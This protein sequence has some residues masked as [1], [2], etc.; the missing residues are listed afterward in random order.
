MEKKFEIDGPIETENQNEDT[1]THGFGVY[2]FLVVFVILF[3]TTASFFVYYQFYIG[4]INGE[5]KFNWSLEKGNSGLAL[6]N[7][8]NQENKTLKLRLDSL[9]NGTVKSGQPASGSLFS[10]N[11]SGEVYYVQLGAFKTFDFTKY[12]PSLVNMFVDSENGLNKLIVGGFQDFTEAC[13]LRRDLTSAGI[14]GVWIIKKV[15]GKRVKF[16]ANCP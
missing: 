15:D 12:E 7:A 5:Y 1:N 13:S 2:I 11:V 4:K 3:L 9:S 6:V 14:K 16:E 10:A 8:L